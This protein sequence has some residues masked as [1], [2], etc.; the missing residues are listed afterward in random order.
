[1]SPPE[2]GRVDARMSSVGVCRFGYCPAVPER[3]HV[4]SASASLYPLSG[5]RTEWRIHRNRYRV[6]NRYRYRRRR[7]YPV[8][9]PIPNPKMSRSGSPRGHVMVMELCHRQTEHIYDGHCKKR[10]GN[11][12]FHKI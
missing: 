7:S 1:M 10:I 4:H 3:R 5:F 6:R 2:V 9:I 8:S 12:F 11:H